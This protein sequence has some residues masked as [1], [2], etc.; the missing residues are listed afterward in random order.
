MADKKISALTGASTPLAGTEVL[1]IVQSGN[2]VKATVANIVGA[3]TSPGSFTNITGSAN[4]IISVTDNTN[5]ALRITQLGTGNALLVEDTTNPDASPFVIDASG[6]VI[7]G[8]T[9]PITGSSSFV[10][11]LQVS[12]GDT[13]SSG[14]GV[15]S[16]SGGSGSGY[17]HFNRSKSSTVGTNTVVASGDNIG[18][19]VFAGA[20][21]TGFIRAASIS[22]VVDGTPGTNDMPG[23][24]VFSTTADGAAT[25]TER[26][27]ISSAGD[28]TLSTGNLV[29]STAAKGVN[30]TANTPVAGMT[31]QLLNWYEEGTWTP[32]VGGNATYGGANAANY[33]RI[34]RLVVV[35]GIVNINAI[36]TGSTTFITNLP[37]NCVRSGQGS[38]GYFGDLA[39][40]VVF[41]APFCDANDPTYIRFR[42]LT[43]AAASMSADTIFKNSTR[44]DFTLAYF[45]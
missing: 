24:L 15:N 17:L 9:T 31:S 14:V 41:M 30:F 37:F 42:T 7:V 38:I 34:G 39:T 21:G 25:P 32:S 28:V 36:G 27:R 33:T 11:P 1:P 19:I 16:F 13:N 10:P 23:R 3:G 2:T 22:T 43:A 35:S 20:D 29:P 45:C 8:G 4:A 40:S 5:A 6:R 18:N 44:I 26:M 12:T